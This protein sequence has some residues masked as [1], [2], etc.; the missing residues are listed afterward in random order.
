[1]CVHVVPSFGCAARRALFEGYS[2]CPV[3]CSEE[4]HDE[5]AIKCVTPLDSRLS[6]T[7]T[8]PAS[9]SW[10]SPPHTHP[11]Q[12]HNEM[13]RPNVQDNGVYRGPSRDNI[14]F[15]DDYRYE[16][17]Q[18]YVS[19]SSVADQPIYSHQEHQSQYYPRPSSYAS[20]SNPG[21]QYGVQYVYHADGLVEDSSRGDGLEYHSGGSQYRRNTGHDDPRI[22]YTNPYDHPQPSERDPPVTSYVSGS[23]SGYPEL[24]SNTTRIEIAR[25]S[26]LGGRVPEHHR[27]VSTSGS[28]QP[29]QQYHDYPRI[30]RADPFGDESRPSYGEYQHEMYARGSGAPSGYPGQPYREPVSETIF[31][32]VPRGSHLD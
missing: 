1:M 23:H 2:S 5:R 3:I 17:E 26:C 25:G 27:R 30:V 18:S 8:T 21:S 29:P 7:N 9:L 15:G 31:I 16:D 10:F 14:N 19:G 4:N 22:V 20:T 28:S 32:R 12:N 6:G 11:H 13:K 24:R